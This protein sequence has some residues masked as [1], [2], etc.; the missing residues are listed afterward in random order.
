MLNRIIVT[1][2]RGPAGMNAATRGVKKLAASDEG[3]R[4]LEQIVQKFTLFNSSGTPL[5]ASWNLPGNS[6]P[7]LKSS[8]QGA[9]GT[10]KFN[11]TEYTISK[12]MVW[13]DKKAEAFVRAC[14]HGYDITHR[15]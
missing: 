2:G 13:S 14:L 7:Q 15:L 9:G 10:A 11:P 12:S 3:V 8:Q 1:A 6:S 5:R 4:L